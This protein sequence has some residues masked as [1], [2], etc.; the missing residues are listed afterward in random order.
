MESDKV[1][2]TADFFKKTVVLKSDKKTILSLI[3]N[4]INDD[5][6]IKNYYPAD[7]LMIDRSQD[8]DVKA[9]YKKKLDI[10]LSKLTEYISRQEKQ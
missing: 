6:W 7:C 9:E 8:T 2:N 3:K 5:Q 1:K 10:K 4:L